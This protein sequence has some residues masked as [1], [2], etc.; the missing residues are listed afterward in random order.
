LKGAVFQGLFGLTFT[1]IQALWFR[2]ICDMKVQELEWAIR[3]GKITAESLWEQFG[4]KT[5]SGDIVGKRDPG[6]GKS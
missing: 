6:A 4:L 2:I 1:M 5:L 3:D